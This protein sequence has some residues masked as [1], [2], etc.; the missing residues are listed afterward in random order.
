[1]LTEVAADSTRAASNAP[2]WIERYL[3]P[4]LAVPRRVVR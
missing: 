2:V 4:V 3:A 1:M